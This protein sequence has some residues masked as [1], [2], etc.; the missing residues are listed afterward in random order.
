MDKRGEYM[1]INFLVSV[2]L[3]SSGSSL[4]QDQKFDYNKQAELDAAGNIYVSSDEGKLIKMAGAGHCIEVKS[5]LDKQTVGCSVSVARGTEPEEAMQSLR[6]EIYLKNGQKRIIESKTPIVEWHFWRDG[7]QVAVHW[8]SP[9]RKGRYALYDSASARLVE[10]FPE[11]GDESSLPEGAKG[12]GQVQ[13][14]SV[15]MGEEYNRE[16]TKWI[17]KVMRQITKIEPGMKRQD[18]LKVFTTE[19]GL[20]TRFQRTYVYSECPYIKVNVRFK[21]ANHEGNTPEEQ[22]DD[23]IESISQPYLAWSTMD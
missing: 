13:D 22:P 15:P 16:R 12:P 8:S 3:A 23:I 2:A 1:L 19:G 6:L 11:P 18:L 14:E 7:Q 5:A 21:A 10:E 20:S 4:R 17:A 9:G